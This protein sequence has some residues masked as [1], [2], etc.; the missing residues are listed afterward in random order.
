MDDDCNG[1]CDDGPIEGC[2]I[3]VHR[4]NGPNGHYYTT[5]LAETTEAGRSL[6]AQD[7]WFV[8]V[9]QHDGMLPLH[10][11]DR[12]DGRFFLTSADD[13]EGLGA[14]QAT[15][16]FVETEVAC[17]SRELHRLVSPSDR[18]FYTVSATERDNAVNNLGYTSQGVSGF[19]WASG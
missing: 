11:C 2:R 14:V 17:G 19:I 18:H 1:A 5:V 16:G 4:A 15:L 9:E 12:G 10:R 8:Y 7:Y 13:C 6:E 3:P